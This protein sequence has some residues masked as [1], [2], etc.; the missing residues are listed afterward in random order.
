MTNRNPKPPY[1]TPTGRLAWTTWESPKSVWTQ[2]RASC[3]THRAH[4]GRAV[5]VG[6]GSPL[7]AT[8]NKD[9]RHETG[10]KP[11]KQCKELSVYRQR[12]YGENAGVTQW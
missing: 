3:A 2:G 8:K 12:L 9:L 4:P 7:G 11:Y 10:T 5:T 6:Y 1:S